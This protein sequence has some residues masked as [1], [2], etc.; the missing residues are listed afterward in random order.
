MRRRAA[1]SGP[2]RSPW[3]FAIRKTT[4]GLSA[5]VF[6]AYGIPA[7]MEWGLPLARQ[8]AAV[9]LVRLL[10]CTPTTGRWDRSGGVGQQLFSSRLAGVARRP[11][12]AAADRAVR[13]WQ[14]PRGRR[15]LLA[16]LATNG[17]PRASRRKSG[18]SPAWRLGG[19][20]GVGAIGGR[21][22]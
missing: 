15:P 7:A 14:I 20:G 17:G 8:P 5:E 4:S 16:R 3:S 19:G 11:G 13:R 6:A 21:L 9:A 1:R 18:Q 12:R 10:D 22:G 2:A